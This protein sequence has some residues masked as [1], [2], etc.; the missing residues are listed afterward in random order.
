MDR[1]L[2]ADT[3]GF[4]F[5][6]TKNYSEDSTTQRIFKEGKPEDTTC[7]IGTKTYAVPENIG[8]EPK[9]ETEGGSLVR[10]TRQEVQEHFAAKAKV[11]G[12]GFGFKGQV[13]A[14]YSFI[15]KKT[16]SNYFGLVEATTHRYTLKLKEQR[17]TWFTGDFSAD[18]ALLP[19]K[20]KRENEDEWFAFFS[21]Y[22]T[23]YVHQVK[24]GGNLYYY[25]SIDKSTSSD[26]QNAKAKLELEYNGV[27][28]KTKGEA[29]SSWEKLSKEWMSSR[30][31]R[32]ATRG[33]ENNLSGLIPS[34]GVWKGDDF[35]D[36]GKSL[37]EKPGLSSFNLSA[38]ST[39]VPLAKRTQAENALRE[40][41]RG[42]VVVRAD[43]DATP[44]DGRRAFTAY[45][46]II[47]PE[48]NVE[49][50]VPMPK[51][52]RREYD[53]SGVQIVLLHPETFQV[54]FNKV[55]YVNPDFDIQK[56]NAMWDAVAADLAQVTA[57]DFY[58]AVSVFGLSPI[59][60]PP[61]KVAS[62]LNDCGAQLTEWQKYI[63]ATGQGKGAICYTFAGRK[64]TRIGSKEEFI[65]DPERNLRKNN[66][67][68]LYFLRG[69][70]VL[71]KVLQ[72]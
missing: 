25:V 62:F 12:S 27:F 66:S 61:P 70:G 48:G 53:V 3:L 35:I 10:S 71:R 17:T 13:E 15:T 46:T 34:F 49:P 4:G 40:Y 22:G 44:Q 31:V 59:Y 20:F 41:L 52:D 7:K 45:P 72:S 11:S 19:E 43:R 5:D 39:L 67:T 47:G 18:L 51:P 36:W 30:E 64:G 56:N 37:I 69:A 8:V 38:M 28:A 9:F 63:G 2:G 29:E 54:F 24:L 58:C 1:I 55:H 6:I 60:F 65:I 57:R 21:T 16:Q 14:A 42:G 50:P 68:S 33:G 23:H 32:V 26:E